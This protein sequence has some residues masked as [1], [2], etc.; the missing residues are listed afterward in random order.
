M[1]APAIEQLADDALLLLLSR[2]RDALVLQNASSPACRVDE[3]M[4]IT[5]AAVR[6]V[7]ADA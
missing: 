2:L 4:E 5:L 1:N 3:A 7:L 6:G